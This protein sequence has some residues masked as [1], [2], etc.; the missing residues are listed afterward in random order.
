[1]M[2][3]TASE[4]RKNQKKYFQLALNEKV[5]V[6][7]GNVIFEIKPSPEVYIN[8]SPSGDPW[9][10]DPRNMEMVERGLAEV[11]AGHVTRVSLDE[12]KTMLGL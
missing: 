2:L 5:G 8:P 11:K 10:D 1:M 9:F 4:F 12:V 7:S 3:V 6:K